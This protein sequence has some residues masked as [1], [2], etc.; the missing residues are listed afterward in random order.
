MGCH[1]E[2]VIHTGCVR[3]GAASINLEICAASKFRSGAGSKFRSEAASK[4][5]GGAASKFRSCAAPKF[6]NGAASKFRAMIYS[7]FVKDMPFLKQ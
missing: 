7:T 2:G 3:C 5:R 4:F 6:R 1:T